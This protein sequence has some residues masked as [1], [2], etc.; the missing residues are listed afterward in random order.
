MF[1]CLN[2]TQ[3]NVELDR[4]RRILREMKWLLNNSHPAVDIYPCERDMGFWRLVMEGPEGTPYAG[5]SWLL[6]MEFPANYPDQ[7]PEMRFVTPIKHCNINSYGRICHSIFGRNYT[8]DTTIAVILQCV[9]GLLLNPDVSDPL[10]ST[11]A[12]EFYESSGLYEISIV[13]HVKRHAKFR[14]RKEW[15]KYL[16]LEERRFQ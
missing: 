4:T 10:D 5:G 14:D 3:K 9:Y 1:V 7:A 13:N 15:A 6:Y 2:K 11:L 16:T 12:L 8:P